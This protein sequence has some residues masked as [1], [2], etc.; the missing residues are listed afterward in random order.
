MKNIKIRYR[1]ALGFGLVLV[2]LV[3][4]ST[5]AIVQLNAVTQQV[6]QMMDVPLT[7]ERLVS[8]WYA[9]VNAG[10]RRTGAIARSEDPSL[11]EFFADD[12]RAASALSSSLQSQIEALLSNQAELDVFEQVAVTRRTFIRV[13][14]EI[15]ELKRSGQTEAALLKL[16]REFRP[17]ADAYL[18]GMLAF[19]KLQRDEIDE[20]SRTL[21]ERA[22]SQALLLA[23]LG[24]FALL[25]GAAAS[26]FIA[27]S[28]TSPMLQ[29][30]SVARRVAASDLSQAVEVDRQDE[31]GEL[32]VELRQMQ[33][34]LVGIVSEV[35]GATTSIMQASAEIASGNH[36][37]SARTE[38]AAS[39]LEETA[40]SLEELTTTVRN[41]ADAAQQASRLASS[42]ADIAVRGGEVSSQVVGTMKS[43]DD[44][45][46]QISEIISV[47]DG[48]AFQ[49]NILA[50]NAAVEA[51]RAGE[52]GRGFAVVAGEVR[53]LAQRSATAAKEIKSLI[54]SSVERVEVGSQLVAKAGETM[55]EI[56]DSVQRVRGTI[57]DITVAAE[58]QSEGIGQVNSAVSLLDQ[59]TQ[60]NAALV[61][62]SAA[63]ASSLQEQANKLSSL[64]DTFRL[65]A[66]VR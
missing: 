16:D 62:Q 63:A 26:Y 5:A 58:E 49:T 25:L 17:A 40:A 30:V 10:V 19:Q 12:V 3:I 37:L 24:F 45:A 9:N 44:S 13:R 21:T 41:T 29:A 57:G 36:D 2:F 46:K 51:A 14:D 39:N 52:Q 18:A 60:Q 47:I 59:M 28:I 50:L 48:I 53:T 66:H 55:S 22:K 64:V 31:V 65:S 43:I 23:V 34:S 1:L 8:D 27:Q 11:V 42:A 20:L 4:M 54:S 32:L 33:S 6:Q 15:T 35:Q 7:K 38:Q 56:V 61:E